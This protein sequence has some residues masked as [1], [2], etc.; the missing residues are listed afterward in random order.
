MNMNN[1]RHNHI[2]LWVFWICSLVMIGMVA[3]FNY[4]MDPFEFFNPPILQGVN[5]Y[6]L[7]G[8]NQERFDRA[9]KI[10]SKK[11]QA[12]LLGSSRVRAGIPTS[13]FSELVGYSAFKSAFAG[14]RFNEI[15]AYF[16]HA[17]QN[18]PDLKAVFIALDFFAFS[19][20]LSP[21]SE[22]SEE[23]LRRTSVPVNDLFKLLLS[24]DTC[25]FSYLT[26]QHNKNPSGYEI[27]DRIH[28]QVDE[29]DYIDLGMPMIETPQDFLK[30]EKRLIFDDYE[31]DPKKIEMFSKIVQTCKERNITLKVIFCPAHAHY[32]ETIYQCNRWQDFEQLKRKLSSIHPIYD[33]SGF[34]SF[35]AEALAKESAGTYFF[36]TSHF[37]PFF[38]RMILDK[39]FG[40]E[41]RCEG[42]GFLLTQ[43]TVD[44]HLKT[45]REQRK[46]WAEKHMKEIAWLRQ[47]LEIEGSE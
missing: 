15:F 30:A 4:F 19:K 41:D 10:I 2:F 33:F 7:P 5:S 8:S 45:L 32:W 46:E 23:R 24:Q 29:H 28:V 25:K 18:Q 43:E 47:Q 26:Y 11:P 17:L 34:S 42:T 38:G 39:I 37:T 13:R 36:E 3:L 16:E 21:I 31:I 14:A 6:K 35:N 27:T 1:D 22:F 40:I 9:V 20:N 44:H 12:I